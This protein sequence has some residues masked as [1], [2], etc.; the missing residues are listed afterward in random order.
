MIYLGFNSLTYVIFLLILSAIYFVYPNKFRWVILLIGSVIFYLFAGVEKFPFIM[1]TSLLVWRSSLKISEI[2]S[3]AD[4]EADGK[5]LRGKERMAFLSSYKRRCRNRYLIPTLI[6]VIGVLC[7]CKFTGMVVEGISELVGGFLYKLLFR[8]E[9]L[10][11][12][13]QQ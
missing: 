6:I 10:I 12:H 4:K 5:Q 2:Y 7:Y 3:K 11:I 9:F 8:L 1:L 13:F